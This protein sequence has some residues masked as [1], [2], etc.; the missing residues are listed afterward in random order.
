MVTIGE[1]AAAWQLRRAALLL[2]FSV[3]LNGQAVYVPN[4]AS[5]TVSG[6]L[7]NPATG[8]LNPIPGLPVKTGT[9]PVQALIHPSGK[10]LYVLAAGS[11]DI[12]LFTISSPS[13]ALSLA[14][15][16]H[17]E[18]TAPLGM[19]IDPS[20][21][22]LIVTS[23]EAGGITSYSV[24]PAN[25]SLTKGA[26]ASTGRDGRPANPAVDPSGR[27]LYTADPSVGAIFGYVVGDG[28]V[29]PI[30]GSPFAAAPGASSLA[31]SRTAVFVANEASGEVTTYQIAPGGSL[32][33]VG[34]PVPVGGNPL[35]IAL[36]SENG[37]YVANQQ[38]LVLLNTTPNGVYPLTYLRAYYA[39]TVPSFV[40]VDPAGLFAFVVNTLSNDVSGFSITGG[41]SLIPV[42]ATSTTG[43]SG[44]RLPTVGHIGDSTGIALSAG[45][46]A[47]SSS[48]FGTTVT[49][50]GTIRNTVNPGKT[51][52]GTVSAA[53]GGAAGANITAAVDSSGG[54]SMAFD[55]SSGFLPPGNTLIQL[56]YNPASGFEAP[57]PM[58]VVYSVAKTAPSFM[59]S[60][61]ST[62]VA[63]QP[64]SFK[65]AAAPAGGRYPG[66]SVVLLIDGAPATGSIPLV[67]GVATAAYT[68]SAGS[69]TA[70]LTYSGDSWFT[71]AAVTSTTFRAKRITGVTVTGSS[72]SAV[73]GQGI[74]LTATVTPAAATAQGTVDLFDGATKLNASPVAVVS[75]QAQSGPYAMN[76]GNHTIVAVFSGD[77]SNLGSS[78][79]SAPLMVAIA[80]ATVAVPSPRLSGSAVY[81]P[82][83]FSVS[84]AP[85]ASGSALPGGAASLADG[86]SE[87]SQATLANGT[88]TFAVPLL[89]VG[90]H[91]LTVAYRGDTS[92]LPA[93]SPPLTLVVAK[94]APAVAVRSVPEAAVSGQTVNLIAT[95]IS[96]GPA[97]GT[98]S[99]QD[100][101]ISLGPAQSIEAGK[102][103]FSY[104]VPGAGSHRI[105]AVYGGDANLSGGESAAVLRV[106]QANSVVGLPVTGGPAT[107]GQPVA[108]TVNVFAGAPGS[109]TP[110]GTITFKDRGVAIGAAP[111]EGGVGS[112]RAGNLA[113]GSHSISA[114]YSGSADFVG[115]ES[116]ALNF[117]VAKASTTTT[118]VIRADQSAT[119]LTAMVI[120]TGLFA[121]RGAVEF[122]GGAARLGKAEISAGQNSAILSLAPTGYSG[123]ATAVYQGDSNFEGSVSGA[124]TVNPARQ[125]S[126]LSLQVSKAPAAAGQAISCTVSLSWD[127]KAPASGIIRLFDGVTLLGSIP[128]QASGVLAITLPAGMHQLSAAYSG[129]T[130]Y[131]SSTA[132]YTLAVNRTPA[133]LRLTAGPDAPAF[134]QNVIVSAKVSSA[135]SG[136]PLAGGTVNFLDGGN[137]VAVAPVIAGVAS[138]ALAGLEPGGHQL[139][140][141]YSGDA[142]WD[143]GTS[144]AA[145]VGVEKAVTAL[146]I[147]APPVTGQGGVVSL[148]ASLA[149]LAP[150]A[151]LPSGYILFLESG[152]R[153][154]LAQA[155]LDGATAA[156]S[157]PAESAA[158]SVIAV[159]SGDARFLDSRS[160]S[161]NQFAVLNAASYCACGF[162]AGEIVTLFW[163]NAGAGTRI[164]D[165]IPLPD[166][167]GGVTAA[168]TDSAAR[169]HLAP[170]FYASPGQVSFLIPPEVA[171]GPATLRV[172]TA[173]G[174][175]SSAVIVVG[176][177]SPGLFAANAGGGGPAAAQFVRVHAGGA[178]DAP[179][180]AAAYDT[181]A[182]AWTTVDVDQAADGEALYLVLYATGIRN[183]ESAVTAT[184]KGQTVAVEYAGPHALYQGLDQINLRLPSG[185]PHGT[186]AVAIAVDGK[187][188]NMVTVSFR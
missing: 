33:K 143:P 56:T 145:P 128:A 172:S 43:T 14:P 175:V 133:N 20:G 65:I 58:A 7:V 158:H 151:G 72:T 125:A 157:I 42:G 122:F 162:A 163:Q 52:A 176:T 27:Y 166:T 152:T 61:P 124:A 25:G 10:F 1:F 110:P 12:T 169:V 116:S 178:Q 57:A 90:T 64:A 159:Y 121:P 59:I 135:A 96:S 80:R 94:A 141:I 91:V 185:L 8:G 51:P 174:G 92:Y 118:L 161:E 137:T 53:L 22:Y 186:A 83:S 87:V 119:V 78:N 100:R 26:S 98:I 18:A 47:P 37:I 60:A 102:A 117:A 112:L 101:G 19:A 177:V 103:S 154:V 35:T 44:P 49:L 6:Y 108:L 23:R 139:S 179:V 89:A 30:P 95:V 130:T 3:G 79:D 29:T 181:A 28:S 126:Q 32:T 5:S 15:C 21:R 150:G 115:A 11:G 173:Q 55:G 164:A 13:G 114:A 77:A 106:E 75:G 109:G 188:S 187:M 70:S 62:V 48:A 73:Y 113:A 86:A 76:A 93:V 165:S 74:T 144:N 85:A 67:N 97:T 36:D 71:S 127:G 39:G 120:A 81:G 183:R 38:Q 9:S 170:L 17:C 132:T 111:L 160:A 147:S 84:L 129:D 41:N 184:I 167:L 16:P 156:A 46:P 155:A 171:E 50:K 54:F 136:V 40:V 104:T 31:V 99:F 82:M 138:A 146:Q 140:A 134:G 105:S 88:A 131:L 153:R 2:L 24:N 69:H 142:N 68:A 148:T 182:Q 180:D 4:Y 123:A 107:Y 34:L 63:G 45:Y 168:V 149:V 66:G